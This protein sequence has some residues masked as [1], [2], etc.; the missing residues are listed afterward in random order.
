MKRWRLWKVVS[1]ILVCLIAIL[2]LVSL[3]S[4]PGVYHRVTVSQIESELSASIHLGMSRNEVEAYLDRKGW[5]H[6]YLE[7]FDAEPRFNRTERVLLPNT[8]R[9]L[10]IRGDIL[11]NFKFDESEKLSDYSVKEIFTGP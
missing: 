3:A 4:R 2:G 6:E 1:G 7:K 11:L 5:E 10:L 9:S 8:S